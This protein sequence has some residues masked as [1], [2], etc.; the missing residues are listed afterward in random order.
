MAGHCNVIPQV[1]FLHL[2]LRLATCSFA[3]VALN[4]HR[5]MDTEEAQSLSCKPCPIGFQLMPNSSHCSCECDSRI[6]PEYVSQ[7]FI[8]NETVLRKGNVWISYVNDTE[9]IEGFVIHPNCPFDYCRPPS[10]P[11]YINFNSKSGEDSQCAFNRTGILCGS[12]EVNLSLSLGTSRCIPCSNDWLAL[13]IFFA[14]AGV[15]LVTFLLVCNTTVVFG[16]ISGL[17][18]YVNIVQ[19]NRHIF[20]PFEEPNI[21]TI[22]IA[23]SSLDFGFETCFYDGMDAYVKTWL[24]FIFPLYLLALA[25]PI[26]RLYGTSSQFAKLLTRTNPLAVLATLMLLCYAKSL[27][28]VVAAFSFAQLDYPDGSHRQMWQIDA[29]VPFLKGKHIALFLTT[30]VLVLI[31]LVYIFFLLFSQRVVLYT[32]WP[33]SLYAKLKP[34][35]DVYL[36]P[37]IAEYSYWRG[38][39]LLAWFVLYLV[40]LMLN[41][42]G[43]PYGS[44]VA[45]SSVTLTLLLFK[46]IL[47]NKI[48]RKRLPNFVEVFFTVNIIFLSIF[49]LYISEHSG[50]QAVLAYFFVS[51]AYVFSLVIIISSIRNSPLRNCSVWIANRRKKLITY[52]LIDRAKPETR[53]LLA[54]KSKR[55]LRLVMEEDALAGGQDTS[56][57]PHPNSVTQTAVEIN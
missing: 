27:H 15:V 1:L 25:V 2:L 54:N 38:L 12:C 9:G 31:S 51:F 53:P 28:I 48:Y 30:V 36:A 8:D 18:F 32:R 21:I 14:I 44:L 11:V 26:T 19:A 29:N 6:Y 50:S 57:Q 3:S 43:Y 7:C 56:D 49:T 42:F 41:S 40:I 39:Q 20:L 35:I 16:T 45:I 24:Q 47:N 4:L 17:V 55:P 5:S 33:M 34:L 13:L 23:W 22:L 10:E 46:G 52:D 37:Y